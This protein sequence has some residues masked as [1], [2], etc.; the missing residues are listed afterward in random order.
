MLRLNMWLLR[1]ILPLSVASIPVVA[2][3][4]SNVVLYGDFDTGIMYSSRSVDSQGES[5][6][7][8]FSLIDGGEHGSTFGLRG[9][10]DLGG[11]WASIFQ[12]EG[13]FSPTT[14]GL[15]NSNGNF[16]G[17]WAYV[18]LDGPYGTVKIGLQYSPFVIACILT[19]PRGADYFGGGSVVY[20]DNI[21]VTGQYNPNAISYT[22][23]RVGGV[24]GSVM[25][26]LG[27]QAGDFR[28]GRQYSA[29]LSYMQGPLRIDAAL[30]N[31]QPNIGAPSQP[32]PDT[33]QFVGR[34]VGLSFDWHKFTLKAAFT[35]YKVA[36][37][38]DTFEYELGGRYA[39]S[40]FMF[41]DAGVWYMHDQNDGRN[42]SILTASGVEYFFSK[43]TSLYSDIAYVN[44][45]G[46]MN[47]GVSANGG[48]FGAP[49][50]TVAVLIG[51]N[52]TF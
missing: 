16:F 51:I 52:K 6:G 39:V 17:R 43:A 26:A 30:Y 28:A 24:Q 42:H 44:N 4:Q 22:T 37:S 18:G 13:G 25:M 31:G 20:L 41:V 10:E 9:R 3:S 27:G 50:S 48:A 2:R 12:L 46:H 1:V 38:F 45:H 23:P 8:K 34:V 40:P 33:V 47:T 32:V 15:A 21:F 36:N 35:N 7:H 5:T 14:G 29:G 19:D 49:G 11:G